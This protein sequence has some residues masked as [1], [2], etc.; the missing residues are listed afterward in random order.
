MA[1]NVGF[2]SKPDQNPMSALRPLKANRNVCD[3]FERVRQIN[4]GAQK[5]CRI[6]MIAITVTVDEDL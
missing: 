1:G 4:L 5:T 2:R 3:P 6:A